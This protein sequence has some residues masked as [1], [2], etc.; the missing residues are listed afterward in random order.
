VRL[1]KNKLLGERKHLNTWVYAPKKSHSKSIF[2][3]LKHAHDKCTHV[4]SPFVQ[5]KTWES[6]AIYQQQNKP[7]DSI[8]AIILTII[9]V[10]NY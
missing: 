6:S 9:K 1:C 8:F 4:H 7:T 10:M 5:N 3:G 2:S